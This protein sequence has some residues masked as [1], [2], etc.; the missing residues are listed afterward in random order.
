M[1]FFKRFNPFEKNNDAGNQATL[2]E[3]PPVIQP[4]EEYSV[5]TETGDLHA[6]LEEFIKKTDGVLRVV[7]NSPELVGVIIADESTPPEKGQVTTL[8]QLLQF[9]KRHNVRIGSEKNALDDDTLEIGTVNWM[10]VKE[11]ILVRFNPEL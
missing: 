1:N 4:I 5:S 2:E 3:Q 8:G 6:D 7:E 10:R 9:L 11:G